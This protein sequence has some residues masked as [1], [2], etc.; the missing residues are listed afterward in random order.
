MSQIEK[1]NKDILA[2]KQ[3]LEDVKK[4]GN[5]IPKIVAYANSKGYSFTVADV[6]ASAKQGQ[7]SE[8]QLNKVAGGT[9]V[10]Q[11]ALVC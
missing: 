10:L 11:G 9:N 7:L 3:M 6:Q 2:N 5:D 4:I 1:F 8:D